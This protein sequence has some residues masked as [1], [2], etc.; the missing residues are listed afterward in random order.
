MACDHRWVVN[1]EG[2]SVCS[3]LGCPRLTCL[4]AQ[5]EHPQNE[6]AEPPTTAVFADADI[7]ESHERQQSQV[8]SLESTVKHPSVGGDRANAYTAALPPAQA[9]D[10][11]NITSDTVAGSDD[12]L[13]PFQERL[14]AV[15]ATYEVDTFETPTPP[16]N[17][18]SPLMRAA[19]QGD[20]ERVADLLRTM[21]PIEL[22]AADHKGRTARDWARMAMQQTIERVRPQR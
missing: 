22:F 20:F 17:T 18:T 11:A 6:A 13:K 21:D 14:H 7:I 4:Q 2:A 9:T 12:I 19:S 3:S 10:V 15:L 1:V 5:V 16:Q 8:T